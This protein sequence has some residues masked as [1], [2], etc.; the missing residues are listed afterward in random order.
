MSDHK[1][2]NHH[3]VA[4]KFL[5]PFIELDCELVMYCPFIRLVINFK[6]VAKLDCELEVHSIRDTYL[7]TRGRNHDR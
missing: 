6:S 1:Y 4:N 2:S 7:S 5:Y 3:V